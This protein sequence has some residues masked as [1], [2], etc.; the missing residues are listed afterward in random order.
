MNQKKTLLISILSG[1]MIGFIGVY[2]IGYLAAIAIPKAYF[3]W[4]KENFSAELGMIIIGVVEQFLAFGILA[5]IA[6]YFLGKVNRATWLTNSITC[7]LSVLFYL[8]VGYSLIYDT[9]ITNPFSG[10]SSLY[11]IPMLVL[12]F[13]LLISTY[14]AST[15]YR[16]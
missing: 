11:F 7:Y 12:P 13:C 15:K 8:S 2:L 3:L 5:L 1:L 10:V 4:F 9:S 14:V 6:G 16:N